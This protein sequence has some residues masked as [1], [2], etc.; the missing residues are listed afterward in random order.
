MKHYSNG[1]PDA[2]GV[3]LVKLK[4]GTIGGVGFPYDVDKFRKLSE[5]DGGYMEWVTYYRHN[6]TECWLLLRT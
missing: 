6:I 2:E 3:Y 4:D 1:S 5:S